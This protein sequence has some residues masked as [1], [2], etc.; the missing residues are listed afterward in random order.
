M[1]IPGAVYVGEAGRRYLA[2]YNYQHDVHQRLPSEIEHAGYIGHFAYSRGGRKGGVDVYFLTPNSDLSGRLDQKKT[3]SIEKINQING[4]RVEQYSPQKREAFLSSQELENASRKYNV[5]AKIA[6][7]QPEIKD[8]VILLT[9]ADIQYFCGNETAKSPEEP[10]IE[11]VD[12]I[13]PVTR[14]V[15]I[16]PERVLT[17][18]KQWFIP[19]CILEANLDFSKGCISGWVPGENP[20]FDGK[21]FTDYWAF[22]WGECDYCYAER[23]HKSFPK[24]IYE[25]DQEELIR[26]LKGGARLEFGTNIPRGKKIDF[27][28]LGKRTESWTPFT[29]DEFVSTLEAC[30]Q[31]DTRCII[32]TKFLPFDSEIDKL[33][34][35]TRSVILYSIGPDE[36]QKGALEWGRTNDWRI[37]QAIKYNAA[38]YLLINGHQPLQKR[39]RKI[40]ET[41]EKHNLRIQLLPLRYP[42]KDTCLRMS[43]ESWD[44]LKNSNPS[45]K[46]LELEADYPRASYS[47]EESHSLILENIHPDWLDIIGNNNEIIRMCHHNAHKSYCG[48]CFQ[49]KGVIEDRKPIKLKPSFKK[50]PRRKQIDSE[51]QDKGKDNNHS[52]FEE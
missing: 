13:V 34:K 3:F 18:G 10:R 4:C 12:K 7:N 27:L 22:M 2:I 11:I 28:R 17:G 39:E 35:R 21:I 14:A 1:R 26:E 49:Q 24:S 42:N 32:P 16:R 19:E 37:E 29:Q 8:E 51:N 31:T 33:V 30:V 23:Q 46:R 5:Q 6:L 50:P 48:G 25:F 9:N 52:L 38:I 36:F 47:T 44:L 41:A 40:I 43:G 20:S 45:Q 15:R